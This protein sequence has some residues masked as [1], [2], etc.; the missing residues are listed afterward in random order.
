M[1]FHKNPAKCIICILKSG[2]DSAGRRLFHRRSD[3]LPVVVYRGGDTAVRLCDA[4]HFAVCIIGVGRHSARPVGDGGERVVGVVSVE[5]RGIVGINHFDEI[6]DGVILIPDGLSERI[7]VFCDSVQRVVFPRYRAVPICDGEDVA[8][9]V[10]GVADG[11]LCAD[12]AR[13][14][15][16]RVIEI[17]PELSPRIGQLLFHIQFVVAVGDRPARRGALGN[18]KPTAPKKEQSEKLKIL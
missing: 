14:S 9:R 12:I 8:G 10:I 11:I 3:A 6:A 16:H 7:G 17:L 13:D 4:G 2:N 15:A 5:D 1:F 18:K